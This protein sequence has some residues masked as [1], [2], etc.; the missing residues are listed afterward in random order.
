VG[1][2]CG[3]DHPPGCGRPAWPTP[4]PPAAGRPADE[5]TWPSARPDRRIDYLWVSGDLAAG[6]FAAVTGTASDHRGV[7]VTVR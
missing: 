5:L 6:G 4:S 7:A 3:D 2:C 1:G